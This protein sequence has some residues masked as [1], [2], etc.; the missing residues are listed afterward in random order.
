MALNY[1]VYL[2]V[3]CAPMIVKPV[4]RNQ[5]AADTVLKRQTL[6]APL[7]AVDWQ[8]ACQDRRCLL[9]HSQGCSWCW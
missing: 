7:K 2:V 5:V 6:L 9:V 1:A 4:E 8:H 3:A